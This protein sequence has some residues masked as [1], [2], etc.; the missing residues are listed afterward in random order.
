[1]S[2]KKQ[3][4]GFLAI[5]LTLVGTIITGV[6][7]QFNTLKIDVQS[8]HT[9]FKSYNGA[10]WQTAGIEK[11]Y[12][13]GQLVKGNI[14]QSTNFNTTKI[15]RANNIVNDE[16]LFD[17]NN[18]DIEKFPISHEIHVKNSK[19]KKFQYVVSS[20]KD[21]KYAHNVQSGE[22]FGLNMKLTFDSNYNSAK[23]T[24]SGLLTVTY[25]IPS[26]DWIL[27]VRL[28]DP[29]VNVSTTYVS[30]FSNKTFCITNGN[31][32]NAITLTLTNFTLQY[33]YNDL[34]NSTNAS[35]NI[36]VLT[37]MNN[38]LTYSLPS[39]NTVC[40]G[41]FNASKLVN[42]SINV[43]LTLPVNDSIIIA[44]NGNRATVQS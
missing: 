5:L 2:T 37:N 16:Y 10:I 44:L 28:F 13:D 6:I 39:N 1:M 8:D 30:N 3:N 12:L 34:R 24:K 23:V 26:D 35:N 31:I 11:M 33:P 9:T 42:K 38:S 17:G 29:T 25:I 19:G 40:I 14:S 22:S 4:I 43:T 21:V 20:L 7:I 36:T 18:K 41:F 15:Y 27:N 32:S